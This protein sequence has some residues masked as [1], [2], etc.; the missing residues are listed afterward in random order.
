MA[1]ESL[2]ESLK[3]LKPVLAIA[4]LYESKDPVVAYYS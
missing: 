1:A 3:G 4:K 2:P